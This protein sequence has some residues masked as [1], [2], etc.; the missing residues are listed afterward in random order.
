MFEKSS[1]NITEESFDHFNNINGQSKS[2]KFFIRHKKLKKYQHKNTTKKKQVPEADQAIDTENTNNDFQERLD[3]LTNKKEKTVFLFGKGNSNSE[4]PLNKDEASYNFGD[5]Y[6]NRI[7]TGVITPDKKNMFLCIHPNGIAKINIRNHKPINFVKTAHPIK[8]ILATSDSKFLI[9]LGG[10]NGGE[11]IKWCATSMNPLWVFENYVGGKA[12]ALF[13]Y[14]SPKKKNVNAFVLSNDGE[15][16]IAGYENGQ[17]SI[18][19]LKSNRN[20]KT[21]RAFNV[22]INSITITKNDQNLYIIS[23]NNALK[24]Y[25]LVN[26]RLSHNT[27]QIYIDQQISK[28]FLSKNENMLIITLDKSIIIYNLE[29]YEVKETFY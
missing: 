13:I 20:I 8:N 1:D 28:V 11:L 17:I 14:P 22:D 29:K 6:K 10:E 5:L 18:F 26:F 19:D 7:L 23:K 9:T 21:F 24:V 16:L 25:D 2:K 3:I 12:N 27:K 15:N 4:Y